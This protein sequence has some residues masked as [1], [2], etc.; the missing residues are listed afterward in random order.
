MTSE[1]LAASARKW[2]KFFP[3][4]LSYLI[5][6]AVRKCVETRRR[7]KVLL[8]F[9]SDQMSNM[10]ENF[11]LPDFF[12]TFFK[13][14]SASK[15]NVIHDE[16]QINSLGKVS[17]YIFQSEIFVAFLWCIT[18]RS[19]SACRLSDGKHFWFPIIRIFWQ[20]HI[21]DQDWLDQNQQGGRCWFFSL[22]GK[23][24]GVEK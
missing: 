2:A 5:L 14:F 18:K 6:P 17:F 9:F 23:S 11:F 20:Y 8:L 4:S 24:A 13:F 1:Q 16:R 7:P 15:K 19:L 12:I 22:K 10:Y 3:P 21:Q